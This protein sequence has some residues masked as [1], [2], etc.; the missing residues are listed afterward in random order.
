M[1]LRW[2]RGRLSCLVA[3]KRLGRVEESEIDG[4]PNK[5]SRPLRQE[6]SESGSLG[7]YWAEPHASMTMV[8]FGSCARNSANWVRESR[9]FFETWP[10]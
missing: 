8:A 7:R 1:I 5:V 2:R 4:Q 9:R 3:P 10:G 6:G